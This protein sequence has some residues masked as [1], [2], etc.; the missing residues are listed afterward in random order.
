MKNVDRVVTPDRIGVVGIG[1]GGCNALDTMVTGWEDGPVFIAMNTDPQALGGC[2]AETRLQ[3]GARITGGLSTGGDPAIGRQAAEDEF[4]TL[5][6]LFSGMELVFLVV[7]LGGGTGTGAAPVIAKAAH[8]AGAFVIAFAALPFHK[9]GE[10]RMT[11]AQEGLHALREEADA[12]IVVPND[13]LF[14]LIPADA[15]AEEAFK[16]AD[17]VLSMAVYAIWKMLVHRGVINID[18]AALRRVVQS[19]GGTS[20][21]GYGEGHGPERADQAVRAAVAS[22]L[23]EKGK[24]LR[25]AASVLVSVMG[26][27]DLTFR[28]MEHI[29][30]VVHEA[31]RKDAHVI[32]G[33]AVDSRWHDMV[34]VVIVAAELW[35]AGMPAD[36]A[37]PAEDTQGADPQPAT[38]GRKK[39]K[40]TQDDLFAQVPGKGLFKD[41]E[42]T[43]LGGENLDIPTFIRRRVVI[44][45]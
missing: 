38:S 6:G 3:I 2:L 12:V 4:D 8:E 44:P 14:A 18:F 35:T 15:G 17:H 24:V 20:V 37:P 1:G 33:K 7:T 27:P 16:Q 22:P 21:F 9:E 40:P 5:R 34:A 45:K 11:Q 10:R 30:G 23:L 41:V 26:G 29:M 43:I 42:P 13:R 28:D 31:V 19:S 36:A 32:I 25:E 39:A